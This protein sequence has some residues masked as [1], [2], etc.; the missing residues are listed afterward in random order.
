MT[1]RR[2]APAWLVAAI[3]LGGALAPAGPAGAS[4]DGLIVKFRSDGPHALRECAETLVR[5]GAPLLTATAD[6]SGSLD[7]LNRT[8]SVRSV[9]AIFR[10]PDGSPLAAQRSRLARRLERARAGRPRGAAAAQLRAAAAGLEHVYRVELPAGADVAAAVARYAADPHVEYAQPDF[11][12]AYDLDDPYLASSGSWGQPYADL[13][14]LHRIGAPAAWQRTQ[15][16][17]VVVAIADTGIDY[18]HPDIAENVWINPGEDLDGNGAADPG[19]WNGIDDDGNGFADDL[20]GFDFHDSVDANQD[21]DYRDPG[22]VEDADPYDDNGHGTHVAGTVAARGDNGIGIAGVA[23]RARVMAVRILGPTGS[24]ET[25]SVW[26]GVL[27]AA[28]NGADVINASWSCS[29]RCPENP[30]A[31][32]VVRLVTGLGSVFV[33]SAGNSASDIALLSPEKLRETIAVGSL[34]PGD[35]LA[36]SSSFGFLVDVVAP[37][38]DVLSLRA[39]LAVASPTRFVGDAWL[40]LSGT[41]MA[42]PHVAGA[43]ALLLAQRPE[44]GYEEVRAIL[45]ASAEDLGDPGHDRRFGAGLLRPDVALDTAPPGAR[46]A[47]VAPGPG[48]AVSDALADVFPIRA[49]VEGS[50]LAGHAVE[51]GAGA[52]PEVW[53]ELPAAGS[54]AAGL[55]LHPWEVGSASDGAYVVRLRLEADDGRILHEFAPL[56]LDRN[57]PRLVSADGVAAIRPAVSDGRVVWETRTPVEGAL[58]HDLVLGAIDGEEGTILIETPDHQH[59]AVIDGGRLAWQEGPLGPPTSEIRMCTLR[60]RHPGCDPVV[61]AGGAVVRGRPSLSGR[62]IVY[63]VAEGGSLRLELCE[64]ERGDRACRTRRVASE[65]AFPSRPFVDGRRLVWLDRRAGVPRLITCLLAAGSGACPEIETSVASPTGVVPVGMSGGRVA[66]YELLDPVPGTRSRLRLCALDPQT[67]A[68]S[69]VDVATDRLPFDSAQLSGR[70][71][72]WHARSAPDLPDV[73]FCVHAG[74]RCVPQRITSEMG[75]QANPAIDGR[76]VVW[77]DNRAGFQRIASL[78]LPELAPLRDHRVRAGERLAFD[79]RA[80]APEDPATLL[81]VRTASGAPVEALGARL[82]PHGPRHARFRWRP[83]AEHVGQ[84]VLVFRAERPGGLYDEREVGIEV[85][86]R[87]PRRKPRS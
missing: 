64:L 77:Q 31:E 32:Q 45:R 9:R 62:R 23:P 22:D 52:T 19:D 47:V 74:A 46:G 82:E 2:R 14:G 3:C 44:L 50:G 27:Y 30:I 59:D 86:P 40:R 55:R 10:R 4:P 73:F 12:V 20:R 37:G 48:D 81:T 76:D 71:L 53:Q 70:R 1:E 38:E 25:A 65:S 8:L 49:R 58:D 78:R 63:H 16:E 85:R 75:E 24:G 51:I 61:V 5:R 67:G 35:G 34:T 7:A 29:T 56:A 83:R 84:H 42:T 36:A 39:A 54:D 80:L 57:P 68:C 28:E 13:W 18:E 15:G 69:P 6:R 33:D 26:R 60:G 41:S 21:G 17:G 66:W 79:V 11:E 72:V 87:E 43:I